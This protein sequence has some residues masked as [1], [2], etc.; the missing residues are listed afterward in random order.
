MG[1]L[2]MGVEG[3]TAAEFSFFLAVPT[4]AAAT[5]YDLWKSRELL[6]FSDLGDIGIGFG[7]AFITALLVVKAFVAR[8]SR[9]GFTPFAGY[10]I[11]VGAVAL[12]WFLRSEERRGGKGCFLTFR[13]GWV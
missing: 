9:Y 8:G 12:V 7:V 1:S 2:V 11:I 3:R 13:S 5:V 4:M 6:D 10:R